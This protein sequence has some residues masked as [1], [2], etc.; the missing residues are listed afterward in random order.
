[1]NITKLKLR[2]KLIKVTIDTPDVLATYGEAIDFHMYDHYDLGFYMELNKRINNN[3][4]S[5]LIDLIKSNILT[6]KGLPALK[7]DETLPLDVMTAIVEQF[8]LK[9]QA[10]TGAAGAR[11]DPAA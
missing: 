4:E 9:I 11:H 10:N 7:T 6:S 5:G 1:M 8:T 2:P 3:D